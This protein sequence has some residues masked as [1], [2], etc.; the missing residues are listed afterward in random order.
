MVPLDQDWRYDLTQMAAR[1]TDRTKLVFIGNPNNPT[2]TIV[3]KEEL[4]QFL[5]VLPEHVIVVMDEAYYE[6]A[7]DPDYAKGM[8]YVEA[9]RN[10]IVLRTFSKIYALAGLR[11]GYGATTP[12]LA[13]AMGAVREPFNVSCLAQ[14]AAAASLH[15]PEQ[16]TRTKRL[17]DASKELFYR[18][19]ARLG[20]AYTRSEANF[21]WVDVGRDCRDVFVQL[22]RRG[23]IVRTGDIF[24]APTHIRVSTGTE[25]ENRKFLGTLEQVLAS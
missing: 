15:D 2:G 10:V 4:A 17:N 11:I 5:A 13:A 18:E 19:F 24:G 23:V 9:G 16:V 12:D 6:Y 14:V 22:L 3:A 7:D 20:L 8:P 1:V 21:V 25:E